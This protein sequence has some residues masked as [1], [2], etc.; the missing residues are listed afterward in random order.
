MLTTRYKVV[1]NRF[2]NVPARRLARFGVTPDA[3]TLA[4]VVLVGASCVF[5]LQTRRI[6]P[7]CILVLMASL[8]DALDGALARTIGRASKFGSYLDALC[9]RI[10]E[11]LIVLSVA[12][13][14]GYWELSALMLTGAMLV[15]YAKAR[16]AMEAPISNLEWPDLM[17]RTERGLVYLGGLLAS[18][19]VGWWPLGHDLFWWTL[20]ILSVLIYATVVQRVLR[21]KR[22]I[23]A[24]G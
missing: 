1:F 6:V 24:R 21:A 12:S 3:V 4:G 15:S 10:S 9:D 2:F 7:F 22:V 17:E 18:R 23:E 8:L 11:A 5:L 19:L 16:A 14:T 20:V 13:V